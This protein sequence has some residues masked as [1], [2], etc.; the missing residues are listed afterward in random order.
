MENL[1]L[2][3]HSEKTI[4]DYK[5]EN[6]LIKYESGILDEILTAVKK[7]DSE[8]LSWFNLF[9]KSLRKIIMNV[10]A[11]RKQLEF[12]FTEISFDQYGWFSKPQFLDRENLIFGNP[13]RYAEHSTVHLGRGTNHVWTYSLNYSYGM[14]GGG[15]FLSVYD[16][17][18]KSRQDALT[19]GLDELKTMMSAKI[20]DS[21]TSNYNQAVINATL[22]DI[23]KFQVD[24]VQLS[25]F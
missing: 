1:I 21:D 15:S 5:K 6:H 18:F 9:G 12:G 25:L 19:S 11:Y 2:S 17:Q 20:G 4:S 8:Q 10:Y 16:K 14:A 22:K 7:N 24:Q 13:D 3:L 23:I